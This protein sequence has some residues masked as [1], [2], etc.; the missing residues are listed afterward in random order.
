MIGTSPVIKR[1]RRGRTPF[2]QWDGGEVPSRD[3]KDREGKV[4][5]QLLGMG[6]QTVI[7]PS[8]H[9]ETSQPYEWEKGT[10]GRTL[11]D[12][13]VRDLPKLNQ[14][15]LA[16]LE[17]ALKPYLL[18]RPS[19]PADES[20]KFE[21]LPAGHELSDLELRRYKSYAAAALEGRAKDISETPAGGRNDK[22]FKGVCYLGK[23]AWHGLLNKN[24]FEKLMHDA[25]LKNGLI[26][27]DGRSAFWATFK[28]AFE[29]TRNDPLP[30][31]ADRPLNGKRQAPPRKA[32]ATAGARSQRSGQPGGAEANPAPAAAYAAQ[33]PAGHGCVAEADVAFDA[34]QTPAYVL[35]A[36]AHKP[37][38]SP[39]AENDNDRCCGGNS[40]AELERRR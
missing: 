30:A 23:F 2:Y 15:K 37:D 21:P 35:N 20:A 16:A 38:D 4:I 32:G 1:G 40:G 29:M 17:E 34:R 24:E 25:C 8:V 33:E 3:F 28:S 6:H 39:K 10:T 12:T 36:M 22:L 7:P 26:G 9:P 27:D 18:E 14:A 31:L 11:L 5:I 19:W 13:N